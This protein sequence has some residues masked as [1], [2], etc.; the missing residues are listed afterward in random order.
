MSRR[1]LV[2]LSAGAV[3]AVLALALGWALL[4][5]GA[6]GGATEY[7]IVD[8]SSMEPA[9]ARGDLAILRARRSYEIGDVVGYRS[10]KLGRLVLHRVVGRDGERYAFR[11]DAN[12]FEDVERP[13]A[14]ALV[15]ELWVTVPYAGLPLGWLHQPRNA[16]LAAG[17]ASL[18][19]LLGWAGLGVRT[20]RLPAGAGAAPSALRG[21]HLPPA[22]RAAPA[23]VLGLFAL[24]TAVSFA[25]PLEREAEVAGAYRERAALSYEA[26]VKPDAVYPDGAVDTGESVFVRRVDRLPV[27]FTYELGSDLPLSVAGTAGL[28]AVLSD[29]G[30]W[31]R[32][33]EL[34][35][36]APLVGARATIAGILDVRRLLAMV[37]RFERQTGT[38]ASSYLVTLVPRVDVHGEIG[39]ARITTTFVPEVALRL[40]DHRL[41]PDG[42]VDAETAFVHERDG[43]I[44]AARPNAIGLGRLSFDVATARVVALCGAALGLLGLV[45]LLLPRR[46][47]GSHDELSRIARAYSSRLVPVSGLVQTE[48]PDPVDVDSIETLMRLA[49]R[50]DGLVLH[51]RGTYILRDG[52]TAY[53]YRVGPIA[54]TSEPP[55]GVVLSLRPTGG[56]R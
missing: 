3:V 50:H 44:L 9:L 28:T 25:R 31:S 1:S 22:A 46:G 4:A 38:D 6:I 32:T 14:S 56:A 20:R 42:S 45:A 26:R 47:P 7:A 13:A 21:L 51:E 8:G 2:S 43:S 29:G 49:E 37:E 34:A 40:D 5:P 54:A 48:A 30:G 33:L 24:L 55:P 17:V 39:G 16:A 53:R 52:E 15:G 10:E 12:D 11:G 27:S 19:V 35:A 18:L 36:P 41:T 23:A